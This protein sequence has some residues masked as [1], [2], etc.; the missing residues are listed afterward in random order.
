MSDKWKSLAERLGAP[1]FSSPPKKPAESSAKAP[2]QS[3]RTTLDQTAGPVT[4]DKTAAAKKKELDISSPQ[5][6]PEQSVDDSPQRKKRSWGDMLS[7]LLNIPQSE[8]ALTHSEDHA[9]QI[10]PSGDAAPSTPLFGTSS[11]Q[12]SENPALEEMFGTSGGQPHPAYWDKPKRVVDDLGWEE[13]VTEPTTASSQSSEAEDISS[14]RFTSDS[15][16][17][18]D[19]S[20]EPQR[21]SRRR[22]RRGGR[23]DR[24]D[25]DARPTR[26]ELEPSA[27]QSGFRDDSFQKDQPDNPYAQAS[28]DYEHPA[29]DRDPDSDD[30]FLS[31]ERRSSR[32]RRRRGGRDRDRDLTS[33]DNRDPRLAGSIDSEDSLGVESRSTDERTRRDRY[34]SEADSDLVDLPEDTSPELRSESESGEE[35]AGRSR[36]R[37][38][39][40]R[41]G[42][43][44]A[45]AGR[46]SVPEAGSYGSFADEEDRESMD[47]QLHA[48]ED[49]EIGDRHRS[50]PT[51]EDSIATLVEANIENHRRNENRGSRGNRPKGRR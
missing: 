42:Q 18:S 34:D 29:A 12:Q 16:T 8:A 5:P 49:R 32:R 6:K 33:G 26:Q 10:S 47:E 46:E 2:Q 39:R 25:S 30:D 14:L 7:S 28:A 35:S 9:K 22:R 4:V 13:E 45:E 11:S 1:S 31:A 48:D 38:R 27:A 17:D 23:R 50:I 51:W 37:R 15:A 24:S 40:G 3:E 21:R 20:S 44:K 36:R 19:E 41:G 43:R